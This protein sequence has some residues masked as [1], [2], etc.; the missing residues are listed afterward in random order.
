MYR[1]C[2][3]VQLTSPHITSH[4]YIYGQYTQPRSPY[5]LTSKPYSESENVPSG[6]REHSCR[7]SLL[8][9]LHTKS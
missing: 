1:A 3:H 5:G 6:T 2:T 9:P 4:P 8:Q 7:K